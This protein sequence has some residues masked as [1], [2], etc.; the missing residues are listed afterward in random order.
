[1]R[2]AHRYRQ[3]RWA[4]AHPLIFA[5]P[6]SLV[7]LLAYVAGCSGD[8]AER[9]TLRIG[10]VLPLTGDSAAWGEQGRWGIELAVAKVNKAGGVGGRRVEVVF[11]DSQALPRN[12]VN[13]F[14]KLSQV[15]VVRAVVGDIVSASTLAMAPLA[16]D[17]HVVLIAPTASAPAI[18]NAGDFVF[19][20][21]PSDLLEGAA[22]ADWAHSQR[23]EK[24][25]IL[26]IANDYG[27][28]LA[29]AFRER[30]EGAGGKVVSVQSYAQDQTDFRPYL[31]RVKFESA[32]V[33]YLVSYY[34]DA[35]LVLKQAREMGLTTK[36]LGATAVE[37]PDLLRLAGDAAEGLIYP[38]I[39]DFDPSNPS[40]RQKEFIDEF[41]AA[42]GKAPD[43]ASSH[44]HDAALVIIEAMRSGARTGDEIRTAINTRRVF[45]GVT[46]TIRFDDHG[47]VVNKPVVM[48]T[49]RGGTFVALAAGR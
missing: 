21:W 30:L 3:P 20:V 4:T 49:V 41:T 15:D 45:E 16:E 25:A 37:S 5:I 2:I 46:G 23:F 19:R 28:G 35:G 24:V 10:A 18:T 17:R 48:K 47:D 26:H 22:A 7:L 8:Q 14:N 27:S 11:E 33:V 44:A 9:G 38:T 29:A 13:A 34:K 39:V 43:W 32:D 42:H 12:A 1:M 31:T 6:C 40:A 36:F